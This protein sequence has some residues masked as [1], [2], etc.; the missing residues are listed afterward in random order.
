MP[1][2]VNVSEELD[3][4]LLRRLLPLGELL[5][6]SLVGF[7]AAGQRVMGCLILL[8]VQIKELVDRGLEE[9]RLLIL[10]GI[11]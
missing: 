8:V 11:L 3:K 9:W 6:Q 5:A 2:V 4:L 1:G 7:L 10:P